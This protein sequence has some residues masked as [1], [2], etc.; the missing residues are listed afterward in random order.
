MRNF[1]TRLGT[2]IQNL[3]NGL[4]LWQRA[5]LV[6]GCVLIL[7]LIVGLVISLQPQYEQL[8]TNLSDSDRT[9]I[10]QRLTEEGIRYEADDTQNAIRVLPKDK[11]RARMLLAREGI[12]HARNEGYALFDRQRL[13]ATEFEQRLNYQR[14][15]EEELENAIRTVEGVREARVHL[16]LPKPTVFTEREKPPKAAVLLTLKDKPIVPEEVQ[17]IVHLVANAVEGLDQENVVVSDSTGKT[18]SKR[19]DAMSILNE[20]QKEKIDLEERTREEKILDALWTAYGN[21][22]DGRAITAVATAHVT[23]DISHDAVETETTQYQ[24]ET[25]VSKE[26]IVSESATGVA[27]PAAGIAG[28]TSNILGAGALSPE[29]DYSREESTTEYQAGMT[30]EVRRMTPQLKNL[31]T[32]VLVNLQVLENPTPNTPAFDEETRKIRNIINGAVGYDATVT[33][34]VIREPQVEFLS[35]APL[36]PPLTPPVPRPWWQNPLWLLVIAAALLALLLLALLVKPRLFPQRE[37]G[38][39]TEPPIEE[40]ALPTGDDEIASALEDQRHQLEQD[41][42][43]RERRRRRRQEL[44]DLAAADPESI[45]KVLRQWADS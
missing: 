23:A 39:L 10:E 13:G 7:A 18:I 30:K 40:S 2:E 37:E 25:V 8:Y 21:K 43:E 6:A 44:I 38:L 33:D 45:E 20:E 28:V 27:A 19:Y 29:G 11:D 41:V 24:P 26:H 34:G 42:L 12:P 32:A 16:V 4:V 9:L 36:G 1:F 31:S 17:G 14:A 3:W 15:L 22:V 35:F 5:A